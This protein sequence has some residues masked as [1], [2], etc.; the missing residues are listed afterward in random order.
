MENSTEPLG[1][2]LEVAEERLRFVLGLT[3]GVVF[4]FDG[5]GQFL[6]IWPQAHEVEAMPRA[7]APGRTLA[8]VLGPEA[9]LPF[10]ERIRDT[11]RSGRTA[12]FE[13][14]MESARGRR[15]YSADSMVVHHRETV[16]FLVRDITA[17]KQM[18]QRLLQA[19]RLAALGTLA[20]G[21]A[22]EVNNPL[23]YVSANLSFLSES[24]STVRHALDREGAVDL[25]RVERA[26]ED[27]GAALADAQ[28]GTTRIL[29]VVGDLKT[30]ARAEDTEGEWVDA[31][32]VLESAINIVQPEFKHRARLHQHLD[33][34]A[35]VRGNPA[36]LGQVFV[37]LLIN[38]A[39]AI[40]PGAPDLHQV[41]VHLREEGTSVVVEIQDTGQGIAPDLLPRIFDPFFSTRPVGVGTG[42]GLSICHGIVTSLGGEISVE[43]TL[44]RGTCFRVRLPTVA[45]DMLEAHGSSP[46][47]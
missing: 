5:D 23:S 40:S 31:R 7:V 14:S 16:A 19:D 39:Q 35:P 34:V 12:H 43:S 33:E 4:E 18:E 44:G 2:Q 6:S 20:A 37:N 26:L 42:L 17:R 28:E 22:H 11:L 1:L 9:A 8:E 30:F 25:A 38:A 46:V 3:D 29:H 13:Y 36:R 47:A 41:S 32:R 45:C 10:L 15:W 21:V 27:C 24:L